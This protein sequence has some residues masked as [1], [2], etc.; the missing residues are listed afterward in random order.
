MDV[1]DDEHG[2]VLW[3]MMK[4]MHRVHNALHTRLL[5]VGLYRG[6]PPV[7]HFLSAEGAMSQKELADKLYL[8]PATMTVTLKRMEKAGLIERHTDPGDQRVQ[9]V[10]VTDYGREMSGVAQ[11]ILLDIR[12][13]CLTGFSQREQEEIL[14]YIERM[15]HNLEPHTPKGAARN[16]IDGEDAPAT[17]P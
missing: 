2:S 6:Q 15:A 3:G 14:C 4:L 1:F 10:R 9:L 13:E 8:S 16:A 5:H 7:L 11:S 12:D 17:R